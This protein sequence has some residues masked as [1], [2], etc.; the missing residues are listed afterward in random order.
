MMQLTPLDQ[1][2]FAVLIIAL[3]GSAFLAGVS[4]GRIRE[5]R[6]LRKR[7]VWVPY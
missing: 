6:L 5:R 3:I 7:G 4:R 2:I 1:W